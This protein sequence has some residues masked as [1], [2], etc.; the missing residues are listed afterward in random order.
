VTRLVHELLD[1]GA[2]RDPD[3]IA[4]RERGG[5][6]SCAQLAAV[7]HTLARALAARGVRHGDRVAIALGNRVESLACAL[8]CA[9]IGAV[10]VLLDPRAPGPASDRIL[11]DC[12]PAL[13]VVADDGHRPAAHASTPWT[14]AS[15]AALLDERDPAARAP[16]DRAVIPE[17]LACL[18]YTSGST[19]RPKGVMCRHA[20]VTFAVEAI[21]RRLE[22]RPGDAIG[23][24]LPL[25]FDYGLYQAL[26]A[27]H[28]DATLVLGAGVDGGPG[29]LRF[30]RWAGA[31]VVPLVPSMA[32]LLVALAARDPEPPPAVRV[33]TSTGERLTAT[34]IERLRAV[35]AG[36]RVYPMYGLTECKRV[37]I[38]TPE[39]LES[40]PESIGRPL[41]GTDC[42]VVDPVTQ[43]GVPD[44]DVGE[45]VVRGAHVMAGYWRD[46]ELTALRYRPWGP[47]QDR[48]LFTG[49]LC[50]RDADGYLYFCGRGDDL[51]KLRGLRVSLTEIELA[52][53]ALDGV[54]HAVALG[55]D[56]A[57]PALLVVSASLDSAA[58]RAGLA[59]RIEAFKVPDRIE[60]VAAA[61]LTAHGKVDRARVAERLELAT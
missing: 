33:V 32:Q 12:T 51:V 27:L 56:G 8:A 20:N 52:A 7:T 38:L 10:F 23:C 29:L 26:L 45:L 1:E 14:V 21:A 41:D 44:G 30:L 42:V 35:F 11:H 16:P 18:V 3:R 60:V 25:T 59:E 15:C 34:T 6:L 61:P 31:D 58:V 19:G 9:R 43:R 5:E 54:A 13:L 17:D 28:A 39:E 55:G 49:D 36:A 47:A 37:S 50:R 46:P 24:A 4:L 40:R 2:A 57:E 48:A 22:L 53:A